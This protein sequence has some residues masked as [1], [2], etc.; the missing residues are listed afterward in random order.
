MF[1]STLAAAVMVLAGSQF[2]LSA[3][4]TM[5]LSHGDNES[6]PT[7]LTAVKFKE[8]VEQYTDN[9][10]EVQIYPNNSLG[11]ETEVAQSLRM[12]S[13]EAEI[14]YTGNLMPLAP[15]AG[16]L[17][18][19]YAYKSTEQ[20]HKA[21]DALLEP[22]NERITQE[23]G[24]RALGLMEKGFRVL[25]TNKPVETLED[26][27]GLKIR[28]SPN[29]IAIQT[30]KSWG[31]EP[32]PMDWAEVFPALQQRVIDGQENPYT[33]AISS[34]FYEVQSDITEIHYMMWTGPLIVS[35]RVF[36]SYP[37][38]I[39]EAVVKA[40]REAVDY[41]RQ[42][43]AEKTEEAIAELKERGVNLHG[44]PKDEE[45]WQAAAQALWPNFYDQI[46]GA[47]WANQAVDIIKS[48][49]N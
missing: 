5:R 4:Y 23:A 18:L 3:D 27:K 24:V 17:M 41:G 11:A 45:K 36:Q 29:D 47:E 14:L 48:S 32:I 43:S 22:L 31:I 26:L 6:N 42:V 40:G 35:E 13:V 2:A 8:L 37:D 39:K 49:A 44:A 38:D 12:G 28:V 30:F 9:K 16:V 46:G 1:K 19:P 34:R 15:S 10:V 25:T 20:A 21:M 33:T 7:H